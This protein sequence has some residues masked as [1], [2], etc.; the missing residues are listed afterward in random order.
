MAKLGWLLVLT[1]ATLVTHDA[2]AQRYAVPPDDDYGDRDATPN[3]VDGRIGMLLGGADVGD[4]DGFSIGVGGGLGYRI[5]DITL[6]GVVDYYRV[7]DSPDEGLMRKGRGL[8]GGGALRYSF[9]NTGYGK[10]FGADFWG[11]AGLGVEHVVWRAGGVL[12][13]PSGELAL[14]IDLTGRGDADRRGRRHE[15][16]YFMAFRS[17]I[18]E[19]PDMGNAE[20]TC[21]GPCT[22]ATKPSRTDVS[23]FFELGVHW[24]R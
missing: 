16:G 6:R 19:A 15:I 9:A 22:S 20:V 24:G 7:G 17:L 12:D 18:A 13:R 14:G 2:A 11:E 10:G 1:T 4:A 8:R 21:G 3:R 23:M 5:G